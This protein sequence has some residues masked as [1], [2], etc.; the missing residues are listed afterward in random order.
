[1]SAEYALPSAINAALKSGTNNFHGSL[2]EFLRNEKLEARNFFANDKTPLKRNQF[3]ATLGGPIKRNHTFFFADYEGS[4]TRQGTTFNYV[5][6]TAAELGGDFSG[7]RPVFDPLTTRP[8]PAAPAQFVRDPFPGGVIPA[9]RQ[10]P[11]ALFFKPVFQVPNSGANRFVYSPA[12]AL[13]A[14]KF[15]VKVNPKLGE[16]DNLV[17]RYSFVHNEESDP[18][19]YPSLGFYPLRSRS[20]NAGLSSTSPIRL[21]SAIRVARSTWRPVGW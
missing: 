20:Q 11:Q 3:G 6:P 13:D 10:S 18:T 16:R 8:N 17:S 4:R 5:T 2:Y 19:A 15:D 12:L 7:G 1:M 14:D 9:N 21:A